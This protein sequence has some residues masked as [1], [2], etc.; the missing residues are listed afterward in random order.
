MSKKRG[1]ERW[2]AKAVQKMTDDYTGAYVYS[3]KA[4]KDPNG[5]ITRQGEAD[6]EQ[7]DELPIYRSEYTTPP[8]IRT[9]GVQSLVA[10]AEAWDLIW[11]EADVQWDD[12]N[13]EW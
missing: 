13:H 12:N 9:E 1:S 2:A 7:A 11:D 6:P 8:F 5:Y 10:L 3:N 4:A